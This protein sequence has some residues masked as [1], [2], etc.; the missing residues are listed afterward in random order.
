[1]SAQSIVRL[2]RMHGHQPEQVTR[3][4]FKSIANRV[5]TLGQPEGD[6]FA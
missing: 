3:D 6:L 5:A 1:M 4:V 2:A